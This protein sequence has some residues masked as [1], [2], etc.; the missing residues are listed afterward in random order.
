MLGVHV[1]P[2]STPESAGALALLARVLLGSPWLRLL[3]GDSGHTGTAFTA[4]VRAVRP[5]LAVSVVK[6][7][8]KASGFTVMACRWVVER[9]FGWLL[10]H[11]R[12]VRD[13]ETSNDSAEAFVLLAMLRILIRRSA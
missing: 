8:D 6:R 9:T 7:S 13:H 10:H 11:R 12:L 4:W 5:K 2:A 3:W 1:T